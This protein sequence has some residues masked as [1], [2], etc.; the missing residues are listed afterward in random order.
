MCTTRQVG[1]SSELGCIL[2]MSK[3]ADTKGVWKQT[4]AANYTHTHT[5]LKL[6]NLSANRGSAIASLKYF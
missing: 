3:G 6:T 2:M 1:S 5:T 4:C